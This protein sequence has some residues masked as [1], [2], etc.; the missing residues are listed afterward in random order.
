MI[1]LKDVSKKFDN[2]QVL[3]KINLNIPENKIIG[4]L[5]ANGSG[6]TTIIKLITGLLKPSE[7]EILINGKNPGVESKKIISYL[8]ENNFLDLSMK[9]KDTI[10]LFAD[11][12][13][14]FDKDNAEKL[15]KNFKID[16]N[17][18]LKT[19]SKGTKEKIQLALVMSRKADIY[20][21]D[22]PI[23]GVDPATRDSI[24]DTI[25]SNFNEKASLLISTHLISDVERILDEVVFI[26]EGKIILHEDADKLRNERGKSIDL[27]FREEFRCF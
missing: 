27:I 16:L 6:K 24:L 10:E 20:I 19:M 7:G 8:P 4:L 1:T 26:S 25:L 12:Y 15:L 18:K 17:S 5:G 3:D 22:E 9:V 23:S 2:T 13:E 21:L 14:D 11:F